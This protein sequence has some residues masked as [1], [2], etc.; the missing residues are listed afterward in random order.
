MG[1]SEDIKSQMPVE[2]NRIVSDTENIMVG[3]SVSGEIDNI[4]VSK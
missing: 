1:Y 2:S 3:P 4:M